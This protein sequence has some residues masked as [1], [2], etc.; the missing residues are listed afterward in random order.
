MSMT[1]LGRI[2]K[3][4]YEKARYLPEKPK[5]TKYLLL[6]PN[7]EKVVATTLSEFCR[8]RFGVTS[9]GKPRYLSSFSDMLLGIRVSE[10]VHGW[11]VRHV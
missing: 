11:R 10:H 6:G 4:Q 7:G 3:S 8:E 1:T 5:T 9:H 2:L